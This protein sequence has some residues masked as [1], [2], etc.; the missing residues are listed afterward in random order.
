MTKWVFYSILIAF[1]TAYHISRATVAI[2][3]FKVSVHPTEPVIDRKAQPW[4]R[5]G[6]ARSLRVGVNA[7]TILK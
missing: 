4:V 1:L 3:S 6:L 2:R 5:V 7:T